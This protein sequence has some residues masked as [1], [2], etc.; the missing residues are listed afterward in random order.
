MFEKIL[1]CLDGSTL[2]EQI[3]SHII[4]DAIRFQSQVVLLR[5]AHLPGLRIPVSIPG[6]PS[7]PMQTRGEIEHTVKAQKEAQAYLERIAGELQKKGLKAETVVETGPPS[8]VIADYAR[9][10]G[11]TL[12]AIATHGH[13]GL[14]RVMLGS[15]AEYVLHNTS[16]PLLMIKSRPDR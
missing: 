14:K 13:G 6:E 12:I 15:T 9:E 10:N 11:F 8:E 16:L 2:S 5:V 3:L 1:V 7:T 4:D